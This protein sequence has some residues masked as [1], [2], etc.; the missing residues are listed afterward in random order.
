MNILGHDEKITTVSE[1]MQK[2][3]IAKTD[4][5]SRNEAVRFPTYYVY[6]LIN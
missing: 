6:Y 3:K 2:Q 5:L 4:L 1:A